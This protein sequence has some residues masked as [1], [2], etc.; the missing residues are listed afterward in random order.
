VVEPLG[1]L[2]RKRQDLLGA[3]SKIIHYCVSEAGRRLSL[4]KVDTT[5]AFQYLP[6]KV[7]KSNIAMNNNRDLFTGNLTAEPELNCPPKGTVVVNASLADNEP[8]IS[9]GR[10]R[11]QITN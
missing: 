9:E 7:K 8:Y 5:P 6:S 1:L 10:K 3:R 4:L 11:Q 2:A